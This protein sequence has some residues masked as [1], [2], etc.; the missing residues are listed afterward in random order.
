MAQKTFPK[1]HPGQFLT[2]GNLNLSFSYLNE[3]D[4][5]SRSA[6]MGYGILEGLDYNYDSQKGVLRI[7][8][9]KAITEDGYLINFEE[10]V[11]YDCVQM[12]DEDKGDKINYPN[13]ELLKGAYLLGVMDESD[14]ASNK[15]S[16]SLDMSKSKALKTT[17]SVLV[18]DYVLGIVIDLKEENSVKCNQKSC[19]VNSSMINVVCRPVFIKR[20]NLQKMNNYSYS[21][22]KGVKTGRLLKIIETRDLNLLNEKVKNLYNENKDS[23]KGV[24]NKVIEGDLLNESALELKKGFSDLANNLDSIAKNSTE[25]PSYYLLFL[26]DLKTAINEFVSFHNYY[27][28]AYQF[29]TANRQKEGLVVLG[30]GTTLSKKDEYRNVFRHSYQ[31]QQQTD[32][33]D[34]LSKLFVRIQKLINYFLG[35]KVS[36]TNNSIFKL[37][38]GLTAKTSEREIVNKTVKLIPSRDSSVKLEERSIPYYYDHSNILPYWYV[39]SPAPEPDIYHYKSFLNEN[40]ND[41]FD[42]YPFFRFEGYYN[43]HIND[44]Y[45][46]VNELI[47]NYDLPIKVV[48]LELEK[49]K[50]IKGDYKNLIVELFKRSR[51]NPKTLPSEYVTIN[52]NISAIGQILNFD[53]NYVIANHRLNIAP[54]ELAKAHDLLLKIEEEELTDYYYAL[55]EKVKT[56]PKGKDYIEPTIAAFNVLN[57]IVKKMYVK[58]YKL[59]E[60]LGGAYKNSVLVL[61]YYNNRV[62]MDIN[63]PGYIEENSE[64]A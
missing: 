49:L 7:N 2:S 64:K 48:K 19:D 57:T 34:K 17:L 10:Y 24:L 15:K 12:Y 59:A 35:D 9:G 46:R 52:S 22:L 50:D 45:G 53:K 44:V 31:S 8:A 13:E 41:N 11:E 55:F 29:Y 26:E 42:K 4:R 56:T 6:L 33:C 61:L 37:N 27:I 54:S 23:I 14:K 60:Y 25:I 5:I 30:T 43:G 36:L 28:N 21:S 62:I 47:E 16:L 63:I 1:Y 40:Y 3:Q 51:S 39:F 38:A 18:K 32:D 20:S 58:N